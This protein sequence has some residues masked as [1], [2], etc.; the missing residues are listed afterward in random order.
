MQQEFFLCPYIGIFNLSRKIRLL[1]NKSSEILLDMV[2][3]LSYERSK[4]A[5][6]VLDNQIST[7]RCNFS[8]PSILR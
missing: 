5:L 7:G 2:H 4:H 1:D 6:T 3:H 8:A